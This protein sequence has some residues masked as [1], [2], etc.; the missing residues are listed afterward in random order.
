VAGFDDGGV[1]LPDLV[2]ALFG[3]SR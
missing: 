2:A 1:E 3:S